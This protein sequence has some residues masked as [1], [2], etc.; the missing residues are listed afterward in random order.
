MY[1]VYLIII[2]SNL[3]A[4]MYVRIKSCITVSE[5]WLCKGQGDY[6]DI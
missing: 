5:F 4:Y 1:L 6:T 2:S 3:K